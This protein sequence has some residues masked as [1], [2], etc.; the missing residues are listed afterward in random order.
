MAES[1]KILFHDRL[2]K[3]KQFEAIMYKLFENCNT[4]TSIIRNGTEHTHP[5]FVKDIRKRNIDTSI[6][7]H[8]RYAP[9]GL[10]LTDENDIYYYECK[11]SGTIEKDSYLEC[12][13]L[14]DR[15]FEVAIYFYIDDK[16][17]WQ[18]VDKIEFNPYKGKKYKLDQDGW[19]APR[20]T[21]NI[22]PGGSGTPFKIIDIS[23]LIELKLSKE[24][25]LEL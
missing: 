22:P 10:I 2:E 7:K 9:D 6:A 15:G 25:Q 17:Y 3:G 4:I 24:R 19:V 20:L 18:Y 14:A 1:I 21:G 5:D 13:Q 8:I 11:A 16:I 12:K 23:S